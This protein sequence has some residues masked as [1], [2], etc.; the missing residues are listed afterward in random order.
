[1]GI[2]LDHP[3][4][5]D[6]IARVFIKGRHEGQ[7]Q[8]RRLWDEVKIGVIYFEGGERGHKP[9]NINSYKKLKNARK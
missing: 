1:M 6:I 4:G 9:R 2:I 3:G 5:P 8:R 7:C